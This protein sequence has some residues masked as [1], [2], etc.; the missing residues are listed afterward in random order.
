MPDN[1]IKNG[2]RYATLEILRKANLNSCVR[3]KRWR[4]WDLVQR[5]NLVTEKHGFEPNERYIFERRQ[6][7]EVPGDSSPKRMTKKKKKTDKRTKW[8]ECWDHPRNRWKRRLQRYVETIPHRNYGQH[9]KKAKPNKNKKRNLYLYPERTKKLSK[10]FGQR[11]DLSSLILGKKIQSQNVK[12]KL[13]KNKL[14]PGMKKG[15]Q[16]QKILG[17]QN[18]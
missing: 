14:L 9:F 17:K 3:E 1:C 2:W 15:G 13:K 18:Q 7:K 12:N 11:A 10:N 4:W 5:Q 6:R 8:V 16:T